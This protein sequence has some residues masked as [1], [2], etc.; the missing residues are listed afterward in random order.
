[1]TPPFW[2]SLR[3]IR[4]SVNT[5]PIASVGTVSLPT[6]TGSGTV[7]VLPV[8]VVTVSVR[9]CGPLSSACNCAAGMVMLQVPSVPATVVRVW[10]PT[11]S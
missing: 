8:G 5:V 2:I 6:V 3:L 4:P 10:V 11:T 9:S 7:L 1:M